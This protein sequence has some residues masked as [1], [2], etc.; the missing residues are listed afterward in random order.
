MNKIKRILIVSVIAV[1]SCLPLIAQT[2]TPPET[3]APSSG[4]LSGIWEG[5]QSSGLLK[6]TNYAIE[7]YATYAPSAPKGQQFGGGLFIAYNL[8]NYVSTGL[9][10][11]YLGQFTMASADVQ[12]KYATHPFS[13][14]G[15]ALTNIAVVPFGLVGAGHP[16][17]GA[18]SGVVAITDVGAYIGFGHLWGG[19]F[20]VGGAYGRWDNAGV[21]SG[22]RYHAFMGWSRGF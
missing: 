8:N 1:T 13:S 15:G 10:V 4:L 22:N 17:G 16:L 6:A 14:L 12:L 21:Y 7:P 9:G 5:I 11:D 20:N 18:S 19:Q 2:N 3:N